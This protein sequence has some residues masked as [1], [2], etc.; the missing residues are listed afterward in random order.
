MEDEKISQRMQLKVVY[1]PREAAKIDSADTTTEIDSEL[2][3]SVFL[4]DRAEDT[5][6]TLF[7]MAYKEVIGENNTDKLRENFR[8]RAFSTQYK[9]MLDT[10]TGRESES[11]REL[12]I[13]PMKTLVLEEKLPAEAFEEYD[14]NSM[15]IKVNFWRPNLEALNEKEL[16]PIELKVKNDMSMRDFVT[17]LAAENKKINLTEEW[18]PEDVRV[19]KRN[20][21]LNT[22]HLE[23]LSD[24]ADKLLSQLRINEGVNLFVENRTVPHPQGLNVTA[25]D[26]D[27]MLGG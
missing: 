8:L 9:I 25:G 10:F 15:L 7:E 6:S 22:S 26:L 13:Y 27:T 24:K 21:L 12:K 5:Y 23:L 4:V 18:N 17:L 16:R 20:A 3:Q 2:R 14:P 11:L 19:L 1:R